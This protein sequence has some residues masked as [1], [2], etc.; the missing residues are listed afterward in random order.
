[1]SSLFLVEAIVIIITVAWSSA[2]LT[3]AKRK[4][5]TSSLIDNLHMGF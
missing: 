5:K 4:I 1:M 3:D 2:V